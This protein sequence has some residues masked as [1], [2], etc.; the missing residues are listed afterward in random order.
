[1]VADGVVVMIAASMLLFVL[2][3]P[4][5]ARLFDLSFSL[6]FVALIGFALLMLVQ[7]WRKRS[8]YLWLFALAWAAPIVLAAVRVASG[9]GLVPTNVLLDNST[10]ASMAAEALL[11]S[12]A[13]IYRIRVLMVERDE[14]R[15]QETAARLLAD[16]DPLTGLM[17]RRAFL[18]EGIGGGERMLLLADIDHFRT[19]NDTLG[20][21]GGD[22]VLRRVAVALQDA[23]PPGALVARLGGEEFAILCPAGS[24]LAPEAVL[25]AVRSARMPFDI[26]VT[27][28]LGTATGVMDEEADWTRL[29]RLAD[30]ALYAAKNAGRDRARCAEAARA[31]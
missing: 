21:V 10:L 3:A 16:S 18:R 4:W 17:N 9:F 1:M 25:V 8:N 11:S 30:E 5:Q 14:A 15:A 28:S 24:P 22:E 19:V 12:V 2:L 29:Y 20:H 13:I 6:S 23:A 26:T 31:A 27:V 7:A